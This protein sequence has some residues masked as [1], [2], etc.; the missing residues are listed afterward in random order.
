MG[1]IRFGIYKDNKGEFRFKAPNGKVITMGEGYTTKA[2]Y[3]IGI[4]GV[5]KNA[6]IAEI[7]EID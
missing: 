5:K 4:G 7:K 2:A 1:K 6:P 3:I